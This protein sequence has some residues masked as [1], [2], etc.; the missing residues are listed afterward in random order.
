[1]LMGGAQEFFRLSIAPERVGGGQQERQEIRMRERAPVFFGPGAG[2][3]GAAF[4][5]QQPGFG[6]QGRCEALLGA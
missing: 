5:L 2:F 3:V 6:E 1:M 4:G